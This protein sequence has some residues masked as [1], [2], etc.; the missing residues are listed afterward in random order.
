MGSL[1]RIVVELSF[2]VGVTGLF[3]AGGLTWLVSLLAGANGI[4]LYFPMLL[5][6]I[7]G[8]GLIAIA[9][10]S[11]FLSLGTLKKSQPADLLR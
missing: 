9:M 10:L 8:G 7:V 11:G 5:I 4:L 3:A 6:L 2:W 1:Q